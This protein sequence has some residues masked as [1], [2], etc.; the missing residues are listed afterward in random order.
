MHSH[1]PFPPLPPCSQAC[2]THVGMCTSAYMHGPCMR[3][4]HVQE[5]HPWIQATRQQHTCAFAPCALRLAP[6]ALRRT[7]PCALRLEAHCALS[8]PRVRPKAQC[9]CALRLRLGHL[10]KSS[11]TAW[12]VRG[13][14][15]KTRFRST[16]PGEVGSPTCRQPS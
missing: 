16:V 3:K 14:I 7:A 5:Q 2:T 13:K 11:G 8:A 1:P 4:Q 15:G 12:A 6:C 10:A 9:A